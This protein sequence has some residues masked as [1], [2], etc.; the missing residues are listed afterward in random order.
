MLNAPHCYKTWKTPFKP[1]RV[2]SS[3]SF[4]LDSKLD[5]RIKGY[6]CSFRWCRTETPSPRDYPAP[7]IQSEHR[8][9]SLEKPHVFQIKVYVPKGPRYCWGSTSPNHISNSIYRNP[10]F[11]Y[12]GT[13]DPLGVGI[14]LY[15]LNSPFILVNRLSLPPQLDPDERRT[16]KQK[17]R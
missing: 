5:S 15:P 14:R 10:T 2:L 9:P 16:H 6:Y 12:I 11:Y 8:W 7:Q 1:P 3:L 4:K 13:L 17:Q